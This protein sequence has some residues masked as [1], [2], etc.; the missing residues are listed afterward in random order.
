[1]SDNI[2]P[3]Y[4][5]QQAT[6]TPVVNNQNSEQ[7]NQNQS[8]NSSNNNQTND[9]PVSQQERTIAALGYLIFFLPLIVE[10]RTEFKVF[11]ANQALLLLIFTVLGNFVASF[12]TIVLIGLLLFPVVNIF[13]FVAFILGIVNAFN[14]EKKRLPLIGNW[15]LLKF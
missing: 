3:N 2:N 6:E 5:N 9:Q 1:M 13:A 8:L 4:T 12:L 15:D 10:P 7:N 14:G 11:H